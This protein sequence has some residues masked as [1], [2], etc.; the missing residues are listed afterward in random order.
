[1]EHHTNRVKPL[2]FTAIYYY[3]G[4]YLLKDLPVYPVFRI[5]LIS[6][7][8]VIV[9]LTIISFKWKISIH[10]AGI[11]GITGTLLAISFRMAMNPTLLIS[12]VILVAGILGT[13]RM[14][15]G[16]HSLSQILAGFTLGLGVL[17]LIVLFV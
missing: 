3:M 17:Y 8:I 7:V 14:Y 12:G 15:L 4:F 16:K 5:I 10:M 9:T 13:V 2:F 11:G 1:M 6:Y